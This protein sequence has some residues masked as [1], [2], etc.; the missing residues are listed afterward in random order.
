MVCTGVIFSKSMGLKTTII[1]K[2]MFR[3]KSNMKCLLMLLKKNHIN[4]IHEAPP[5]GLF[6]L[7]FNMGN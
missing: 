1:V 6:P 5:N 2:D 3:M 4:N 7:F